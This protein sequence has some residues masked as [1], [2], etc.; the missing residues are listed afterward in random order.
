MTTLQLVIAPDPRL[1]QKSAEVIEFDDKLRDF[2]N[3]MLEAM[4]KYD[5]AGLAAIQ[6][7]V[8]SRILIIDI[9]NTDEDNPNRKKNPIFIINPIILATS[10]EEVELDEGCLSFPGQYIKI[11]RSNY[12]KIRFQ[13]PHGAFHEHEFVHWQARAVLHEFDHL[14]GI[15]LAD[16][17]SSMKRNIMYRKAEKMKKHM[18]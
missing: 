5:G 16:H 14:E 13:D 10:E 9:D 17:A 3:D 12:V 6:V 2:L 7:G 15:V 18:A 11:K 1:K 4:Y 8:P